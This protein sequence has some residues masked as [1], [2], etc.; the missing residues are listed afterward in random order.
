MKFVYSLFVLFIL[1]L[2]VSVWGQADPYPVKDCIGKD[3]NPEIYKI[4]KMKEGDELKGVWEDT[5]T[6]T[7]GDSMN[8]ASSFFKHPRLATTY[9]P[10]KPK[11]FKKL[12]EW[13]KA[14]CGDYTP[15]GVQ[16]NNQ[17]TTCFDLSKNKG[18]GEVILSPITLEEKNIYFQSLFKD[19][20][21]TIDRVFKRYS[22]PKKVR[23][24]FLIPEG[25]ETGVRGG[26]VFTNLKLVSSQEAE[27]PFAS[28]YLKVPIQS[29]DKI[30]SKFKVD[31]KKVYHDNIIVATEILEIYE[32]KGTPG[33]INKVC[34]DEISNTLGEK[35][36]QK[37]LMKP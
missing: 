4:S 26:N 30:R 16:Y 20:E 31:R 21:F 5:I 29:Y 36:Y 11:E 2:S 14:T 15:Y 24:Y 28:G 35:Y 9:A 18:I 3:G 32:S 25:V 13:A 7:P 37:E 34:I 22:F 19:N 12:K 6:G 17:Y 8:W 23:F 33:E 1:G 10:T 27:I